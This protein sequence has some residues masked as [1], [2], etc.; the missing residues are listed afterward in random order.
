MYSIVKGSCKK[1]HIRATTFKA[2]VSVCIIAM[3]SC[4]NKVY[5]DTL[6][7]FFKSIK[8]LHIS[9]ERK[10]FLRIFVSY[11]TRQK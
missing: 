2:D 11:K 8:Y 1:V 4:K 5:I 9:I 3:R 10:I 7:I 6:L